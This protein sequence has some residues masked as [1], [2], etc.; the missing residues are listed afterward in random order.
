[1]N[2][3]NNG[4]ELDY[5]RET[6]SD[7]VVQARRDSENR[8]LAGQNREMDRMQFLEEVSTSHSDIVRNLRTRVWVLPKGVSED[9]SD[10]EDA[11]E[12]APDPLRVEPAVATCPLCDNELDVVWG[13]LHH[14]PTFQMHAGYC[15]VCAN[16]G[17]YAPGRPCPTCQQTITAAMSIQT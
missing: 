9:K 15:G 6:V 13:F 2:R 11:E 10:D 3:L 8:L 12:F 4:L 14:G 16:S 7:L 1:M 17:T 5:D